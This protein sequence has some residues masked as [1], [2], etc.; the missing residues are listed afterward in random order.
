MWK[1][2]GIVAI[3]AVALILLL[4][5]IPC[6]MSLLITDDDGHVYLEKQIRPGDA[7]SL[8]F[9][10]SVEKVLVVDTFLVTEDCRLLLK[11]TTYGS[12]GAGLPSDQSYN[13]TTDSS[14]NFTIE[15]IDS[16]FEK[17]DF[18]AIDFTRHYL[19]VSGET[20]QL[21]GIVPYEKPLILS[22]NRNT[23]ATMLVNAIRAFF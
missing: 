18:M 13:I 3:L 21:S 5:F 17:V 9:K 6:G 8:G 20:Y 11:N 15:N 23:P 22:V 16:I 19:V 10:H 4:F 2:L 14:G 1:K 12:T 7:V